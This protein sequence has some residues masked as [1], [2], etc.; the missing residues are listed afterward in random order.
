MVSVVDN[1]AY[2]I[3]VVM[4]DFEKKNI[5][6]TPG[7]RGSVRVLGGD[8]LAIPKNAPHPERAIKL[9]EQVVAKETQCALAEMLFWVPV[10]EDVHTELSA[11]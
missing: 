10:R 4:G 11:H 3:K 9:I 6:V 2:G 1:W 8:V 7:W 5:K